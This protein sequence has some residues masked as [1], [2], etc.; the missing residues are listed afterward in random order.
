M[1]WNSP[2]SLVLHRAQGLGLA[3]RCWDPLVTDWGCGG[4]MCI[5]YISFLVPDVLGGSREI[6]KKPKIVQ[7]IHGK[8][9]ANRSVIRSSFG[10]FT[11]KLWYF[12]ICALLLNLFAK[13]TSWFFQSI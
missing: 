3:N 1:P 9:D 10:I 5:R 11:F 6:E 7:W 4:L 2:D 8:I 13:H 12:K